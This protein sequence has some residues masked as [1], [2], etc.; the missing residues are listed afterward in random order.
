MW[1]VAREGRRGRGGEGGAEGL[2]TSPFAFKPPDQIPVPI[3][4]VNCV[5]LKRHNAI[6]LMVITD[7]DSFRGGGAQ[8]EGARPSAQ[9]LYSRAGRGDV[10]VV[11][12]SC[13]SA[14]IL[15]SALQQEAGSAGLCRPL[16]APLLTPSSGHVL[17]RDPQRQEKGCCVG[18]GGGLILMSK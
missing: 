15:S 17:F 9:L 8:R 18:W 12:S 13:I 16:A 11:R 3:S 14:A 7:A 2:F 10:L 4:K 6:L 1:E 5:G